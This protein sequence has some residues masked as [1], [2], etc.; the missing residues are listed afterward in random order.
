MKILLVGE[1]SGVHTNLAAELKRRGQFV[2]TISNGDA[3]K[4]FPADIIIENVKINNRVLRYIYLVLNFLGVS[5]ILNYLK[6]RRILRKL[7]RFDVVQ[8]INPVAIPGLSAFGNILLIRYLKKT[9]GNFFLCA[10][11][12][13]YQ[14][15]KA[16]LLGKY[17]Y[18]ALD[19]IRPLTVTK[20]MRYSYSLKYV[21]SPFYILLDYY[22]RSAARNIIPGLLDYS[23]AYA[24]CRKASQ[25]V[26]LPIPKEMFSAP[27]PMK[28]KLRIFHGWQAGKELKKGNDILH[29]AVNMLLAKYGEESISYTIAQN[30]KYEDYIKEYRDC[31]IYLD[32]VYSYDRG[33]SG[34]LGMCAGKVVFSG[35]EGEPVHLTAQEHG[36]HEI[37]QIGVNAMP[38]AVSIFEALS[39]LYENRS[40]I[41]EIKEA[42][43]KKSL[44]VYSANRV[45]DMYIACWAR[46]GREP[47][48]DVQGAG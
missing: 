46:W 40:V 13:D 16:C 10:L 7:P 45:A 23:I 25:I 43:Y 41:Q 8:F 31:D 18:S 44:E 19:R 22:A 9:N 37:K 27:S 11:G 26:P 2:T 1:F 36:Y 38:D 4:S 33:V 3:Y 21:V 5:G 14:W 28:E 47:L 15:V 30:M 6:I 20:V 35:F 48:A 12:D 32:Q 29:A 39:F 17:K 24:N 42:A 34:A